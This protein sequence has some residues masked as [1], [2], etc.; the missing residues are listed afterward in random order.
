M[1][2]G[3]STADPATGEALSRQ[4]GREVNIDVLQFEGDDAYVLTGT[5]EF[6]AYVRTELNN[7]LP[8]ADRHGSLGN[9]EVLAVIPLAA[10]DGAGVAAP[11]YSLVY[12]KIN[13]ALL[14][15]DE[16]VAHVAGDLSAIRFHCLVITA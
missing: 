1:A 10:D 2:L 5:P 4:L 15:T 6:T 14:V 7:A 9:R 13:D 16:G 11:E 8:E 12:D 3:T